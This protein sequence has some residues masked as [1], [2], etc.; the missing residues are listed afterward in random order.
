MTD[1]IKL[2]KC[3]YLRVF[4]PHWLAPHHVFIHSLFIGITSLCFSKGVTLLPHCPPVWASFLEQACILYHVITNSSN[5]IFGKFEHKIFAGTLRVRCHCRR[6]VGCCVATTAY[7]AA[8][9]FE[10]EIELWATV[11]VKHQTPSFCPHRGGGG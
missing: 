5:A 3:Y 6:A 1:K 8:V 2:V 7:T 10:I 11:S 9:K 4:A